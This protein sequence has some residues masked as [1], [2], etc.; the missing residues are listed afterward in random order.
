MQKVKR[1]F[2]IAL[3]III[4]LSF[5]IFASHINANEVMPISDTAIT[6]S[7]NQTNSQLEP[8]YSD[9]YISEKAQ[10]DIK[11]TIDG[12]VFS[13]VDTLNIDS[14]DNGGVI[15]GNLYATANTVNIKSN[16]IYSETEKDEFGN[17]KLE[18]VTNASTIYGNV[19]VVANKFVLEP[20]CEINGDLYICANEIELSQNA[21]IRG[22]VFVVGNTLKLNCE[23][24]GGDLYATVKN[25]NMKYYGFIYRDLHLSAQNVNIAGYVYRNSFITANIIKTTDTFINKKDFNVYDAS[26]LA[27]SGEVKG[28]ANINSKNISFISQNDDGKSI[29]CRIYGNLT[30]SSQDEIEIQDKIVLGEIH[31]SKYSSSNNLLSKIGEYLLGLVTTLIS[32]FVIYIII[33]KFMPKYLDRLSTINFSKILAYL[34]IGIA[35]LILVPIISI[36]LFITQIGSLLGLFLVILYILLLIIAKPIFI[37][38]ISKMIN[39]KF[40]SI[41]PYIGILITTIVL[42]LIDLIPY[43]GFIISLLVLII[44]LGLIIKCPKGKVK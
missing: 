12:N 31:Y 32:I 29:T 8:R 3:F 20:K 22:N 43:I 4:L 39:N 14:S 28:N 1:K 35:I 30:Y 6:D 10:Y 38:T 41:N 13:S 7:T 18:S 26:N 34:G 16:V 9:L 44:G 2:L 19:F 5:S 33:K 36:L 42:S 37:I 27:F 15:T 25:F 40:S 24:N 11:N 17:S 23:I 21:I